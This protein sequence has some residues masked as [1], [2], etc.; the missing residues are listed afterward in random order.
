MSEQNA[1]KSLGEI[2]QKS[3]EKIAADMPVENDAGFSQAITDTITALKENAEFSQANKPQ[4]SQATSSSTP[5]SDAKPWHDHPRDHY[6]LDAD[7]FIKLDAKGEPIRAKRGRPRQAKKGEPRAGD[8]LRPGAAVVR[9]LVDPAEDAQGQQP[10]EAATGAE[11]GPEAGGVLTDLLNNAAKAIGGEAVAM[12]QGERASIERAAIGA[13]QGR[14][15]TWPLALG[16]FVGAW[17]F[18]LGTE[19]AARKAKEKKQGI[20]HNGHDSRDRDRQEQE[21][22]IAPGQEIDEGFSEIGDEL[23]YF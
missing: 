11:M 15:L 19:R 18:R 8:F 7:G 3:N 9:R 6:K 1:P 20:K 14:R 16:V 13:T 17:L 5:P 2:V 23:A 10:G 4:N 21:R 22:Q 12:S